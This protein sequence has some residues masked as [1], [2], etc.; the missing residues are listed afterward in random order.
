MGSLADRIA[1]ITGASRGIG[2]AIADLFLARGATVVMAGRVSQH[3][4]QALATFQE[5]YGERVIALACDVADYEQAQNLGQEVLERFGRIDILVNNAGI[6]RDELILRMKESDWDQ[7]LD[8][9]LKGAFNCC[10]AVVR[11]MMKKRY[12]RI[13]NISSVSGL[14][15]QAGQTNYSASKAGMIGMTKSLAREVA[16]R[17]ITVNAV[18]PGFIPTNLTKDLPPELVEQILKVTPMG[19]MGR[20]E[21]VASAV[22]FLASEEAS[23]ITGQVLAVDGG[24]VMM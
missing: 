1:I 8:V 4:Q 19:R 3:A 7:V 11:P 17:G 15:G 9:N 21:E 13:V 6:T 22:A 2:Q 20:P 10:K 18:A 5:Q 14:A 24:M 16:S 12:G 23:Y